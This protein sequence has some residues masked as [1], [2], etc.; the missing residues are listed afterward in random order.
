MFNSE[1]KDLSEKIPSKGMHVIKFNGTTTLKPWK[2]GF[3]WYEPG[4]IY[5][6]IL[7]K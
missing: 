1:L 5:S 2:F 4:Y 3:A 6:V 7:F